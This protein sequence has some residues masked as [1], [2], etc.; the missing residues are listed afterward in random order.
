MITVENPEDGSTA[1]VNCPAQGLATPTAKQIADA[2]YP[3]WTLIE[4]HAERPVE[5]FTAD[6]LEA[7]RLNTLTRFELMQEIKALIAAAT[8]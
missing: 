4:E 8:G 1:C 3:G 7:A 6:Q 5:E 2:G